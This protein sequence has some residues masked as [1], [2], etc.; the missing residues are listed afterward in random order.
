VGS[1]NM[2]LL[3]ACSPVWGN[4]DVIYHPH[5]RVHHQSVITPPERVRFFRH[6]APEDNTPIA[7]HLAFAGPGGMRILWET[8]NHTATSV[9]RY[10]TSES[11]ALNTTGYDRTYGYTWTHVVHLQN[12]NYSTKYYYSCGDSTAGFGPVY[13]FTTAPP[14]GTRDPFSVAIIGDLGWFDGTDTA[15]ALVARLSEVNWLLHVGDLGYAD[16]WQDYKNS[17][18]EQTYEAFMLE[19][20][21]IAS[22]IPYMALPGNH[23]TTCSESTPEICPTN[24]KNFTAYRT[25]FEFPYQESGGSHNMWYSFDYNMVHWIKIN[26]ETDFPGAPE[27][28]GTSLN[29]GPFGDQ[30][31]WIEADLQKANANRAKVPWVVMSGH[32]PV[33]FAGGQD[34]S[35]N[36]FFSDLIVKYKVDFYL[37]GH[38]HDYERYFPIDSTGHASQQNYQNPADAIYIINGAGGNSEGHSGSDEKPD[39]LAFRNVEDFGWAKMTWK[40]ASSIRWEFYNVKNALVDSVDIY[41]PYV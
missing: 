28:P 17:S 13:N 15:S 16:D 26:T 12:L 35:V 36:N 1:S 23:E 6:G 38:E 32:R 22:H 2:L 10:G 39:Y 40:D 31:A 25:R 30:Q 21:P 18:Y 14:P 3:L 9:C 29:A 41:K 34:D 4:P 20:E 37:C 8:D 27:N 7:F 33:W 24:Q 19:I 11:L 5:K